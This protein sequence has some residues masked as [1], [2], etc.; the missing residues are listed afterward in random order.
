VQKS[1]RPDAGHSSYRRN[2]GMLLAMTAAA[3]LLA[4]LAT[5]ANAL[6]FN[7]QPSAGPRSE[8]SRVV[9]PN[10][11]TVASREKTSTKAK[12]SEDVAARAKGVLTVVISLDKQQL[13]LY[14]DGH[15]VTRS[16]VS[17][18][19]PGH[20]TPTGVF[21]V[22]QKDRWHRSN[23]YYNAPM[24]FMQRITWSGG[25]M[26]Q[27]I[28]PNHPIS[29]GCSR[30]PEAFARQ[31]WGIT[32]MGARVVIARGEVTPAPIS[33]DR[34]FTF[35][36]PPDEPKPEIAADRFQATYG[37][38][39]LAQLAAGK[40]AETTDGSKTATDAAKAAPGAL[41]AMAYAIGAPRESAVTFPDVTSTDQTSKAKVA[42]SDANPT[43]DELRP[44]K[45]GPISVFISRKEGKLF[46]RKGFD[47]VFDVPVTFEQPDQPLGTH[48][49]TALDFKDDNATLRWHVMTMPGGAAPALAKKAEKGKRVEIPVA[50]MMPASSASDALN[51][52]TIP[53]E[54]LDRISALMSPGASLIIS[55]KGLGSETGKGTDFIVLTR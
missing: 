44:L 33:H 42:K 54:A 27:G 16:R 12:E 34:L 20:P 36:R 30:L 45:P 40:P 4:G 18:G 17:T 37:T 3:A 38:L 48:V 14:S 32:K 21:S 52:V 5:S 8:S 41:D 6:P 51:R 22:I 29:H 7:V 43:M 53:Q 19:V 49:F 25:A 35:K 50:T 39:E 11:T 47:P 13:T 24:F 10:G 9:R 15:P 31:M 46:V 23:L 26:H 55:D 2:R 28:V 1:H